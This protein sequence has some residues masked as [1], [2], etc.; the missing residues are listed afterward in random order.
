MWHI[1]HRYLKKQ[2]QNLHH[3]ILTGGRDKSKAGGKWLLQ[4][5][6]EREG[7]KNRGIGP[8]P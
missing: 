5:L 2:N 4:S 1:K 3:I 7:G 8:S 6:T